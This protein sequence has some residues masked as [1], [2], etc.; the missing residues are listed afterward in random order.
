MLE[1]IR[2]IIE[3]SC[4]YVAFARGGCKV[5]KCLTSLFSQLNVYKIIEKY[6]ME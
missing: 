5:I 6:T 2:V 3:N 4:K 1:I